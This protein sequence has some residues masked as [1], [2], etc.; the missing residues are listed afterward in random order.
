MT[1]YQ[2]FKGIIPPVSTIFDDHQQFD[3]KGTSILIDHLIASGVDGLFFLGTGGEFSQMSISQRK[4]VAEFAVRHV[5]GR[6][7][8]L[9]GTGGTSTQEVIDLSLHAK[10]VGADG[11]VIIN[12]YYWPLSEDNLYQH[13]SKII[14]AVDLSILLYNF[15]NLTGQDLTPSFVKKLASTYANVVGI[16]ETVDEAGHI[17][18]MILKVKE[19]R[20]DFSVLAGFDDHLFNTL[21]LGGDGA[22]SASGNFAPELTIGIYQAF[23]EN[24]LEKAIGLHRQLAPLPLMYKLDSPFV[25]VIKEAMVMRGIPVSTNVLPPSTALSGD[26][27]AELRKIL[28]SAKLTL[29][30]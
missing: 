15:P 19:V 27:K 22:I 6:V 30:K 2:S 14:E 24:D 28:E 8:V 26:K 16:K 25:G 13:Y 17:R 12:P 18:E 11:V 10:E 21:A 23:Q 1:T 29:N 3:P 5:N 4:Q 9:I 7:P 20:P